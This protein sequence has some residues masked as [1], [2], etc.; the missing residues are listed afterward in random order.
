M[1]LLKSFKKNTPTSRFQIK[2][3]FFNKY[4]NIV[5]RQTKYIGV[6]KRLINGGVGITS[7]KFKNKN[8]LK[9]VAD[10]VKFITPYYLYNIS[11]FRTKIKE[12]SIIKNIYNFILIIPHVK[13][14]YP[15]FK[16][17][18][19]KLLQILNN[20]KKFIGQY[21]PLIY[22]P[23][24]MSISYL[25]NIYN[26]KSTFIKSSGTQGIRKRLDKFTKLVNILLPSKQIKI[27]PNYILAIFSE[28]EN[29]NT[30]KIVEG[31]WGFFSK[32]K[33]RIAVRGVAKNP[34]DHPNG[35][36]TKSKQPE[37]SPWGWIAKQKK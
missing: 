13:L 35:G 21:L 1:L 22:I 24:N 16:F 33:K 23:I 6:N 31:S 36:R 26:T 12:F 25:F 11:N 17:Y 4:I 28:L 7:R 30:I 8:E 2:Y 29:L 18:P 34:V 10:I 9:G 15:G 19:L 27:F 3:K 5:E 20:N 37:L 14:H 32:Q